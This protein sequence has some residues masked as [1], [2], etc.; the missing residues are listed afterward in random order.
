LG[1]EFVG[2]INSKT[3]D[4]IKKNYMKTLSKNNDEGYEEYARLMG[5]D[6]VKNVRAINGTAIFKKDG[7]RIKKTKE[8]VAE[9]LAE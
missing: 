7:K 2:L 1:E 3:Q 5:Y 4:S 9:F 8:E 6:E